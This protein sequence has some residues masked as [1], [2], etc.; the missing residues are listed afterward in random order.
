MNHARMAAAVMLLAATAAGAAGAGRETS[1]GAGTRRAQER[2][3]LVAPAPGCAQSTNLLPAEAALRAAAIEIAAGGR[4]VVFVPVEQAEGL[5]EEAY[6]RIE[7]EWR[8]EEDEEEEEA[9]RI[10]RKDSASAS[11]AV[12]DIEFSWDS[13]EELISSTRA[14]SEAIVQ[15]ALGQ[16]PGSPAAQEISQEQKKQLE[17]AFDAICTQ[18]PDAVLA[19]AG[20]V[21]KVLTACPAS[22]EARTAACWPGLMLAAEDIFGHFQLRDRV[23]AVPLAWQAAAQ[24]AGPAEGARSKLTTAWTALL[25]GFPKETL[26]MLQAADA[27]GSDGAPARALRMYATRDWRPLAR[28]KA[29]KATAIEQLAWIFAMEDCWIVEQNEQGLARIM[30]D[31]KRACFAQVGR[32]PII[33][34]GHKYSQWMV[35]DAART[36]ITEVGAL[37]ALAAE[38]RE[39]I[40][41][42][43]GSFTVG[44]LGWNDIW[45]GMPISEGVRLANSAA[46]LA[47][48]APD[49]PVRRT[50]DGTCVWQ[51]VSPWAIAQVERGFFHQMI[52]LRADYMANIWNVNDHAIAYLDA[53]AAGFEDEADARYFFEAASKSLSGEA[54]EDASWEKVFSTEMGSQPVGWGT[55]DLWM[56]WA[57]LNDARATLGITH[58][59]CGAWET[60]MCLRSTSMSRYKELSTEWYEA[61]VKHDEYN[62]MRGFARTFE[63][64]DTAKLRKVAAKMP[65]HYTVLRTLGLQAKRANDYEAAEEFLRGA[66]AAMPFGATAEEDL[67]KLYSERGDR[68]KAIETY[69]SLLKKAPNGLLE[70][71]AKAQMCRLLIEEGKV[72][73]ALEYGKDASDAYLVSGMRAYADALI[74]AGRDQEG[75]DQYRKLGYRYP[76]WSLEYL[77]RLYHSKEPRD[78]IISEAKALAEAHKGLPVQQYIAGPLIV[79]GDFEAALELLNGPLACKT[80]AERSRYLGIIALLDDNADEAAR[81]FNAAIDGKYLWERRYE[82]APYVAEQSYLAA[83]LAKDEP[84][85]EKALRYIAGIKRPGGETAPMVRYLQGEITREAALEGA[86]DS[87]RMQLN[88]NWIFGV[89]EEAAGRAAEALDYYRR[90]ADNEMAEEIYGGWFVKQRVKAAAGKTPAPAVS[91]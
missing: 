52:Q 10:V 81:H 62:R 79:Q 12:G 60:Q 76:D 17:E 51:S 48:E 61:I 87:K 88:L 36:L 65:Y 39:R 29:A 9:W 20:K 82:D 35:L 55:A 91:E 83:L 85:E 16:T 31:R 13:W 37:E 30:Q 24:S 40:V 49:G 3:Y 68:A 43:A 4:D 41:R 22:P 56:S 34:W 75:L 5:A 71:S 38:R 77:F 33:G 47:L 7:L 26:A 59:P 58:F 18:G 23:L 80:A 25:C 6:P 53:V 14:G 78:K 67:G 46:Q 21:D 54:D 69:R 86:K 72:E 2:L 63:G 15:A 64:T 28:G 50:A 44:A 74:A 32:I 70:A 66:V 89:E 84:L 73:E 45:P 27:E 90:A 11:R 57:R 19:A 1:A 42:D 8:G